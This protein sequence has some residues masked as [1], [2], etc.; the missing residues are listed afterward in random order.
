MAQILQGCTD[1]ICSAAFRLGGPERADLVGDDLLAELVR[2][3][4]RLAAISD[5]SNPLRWQTDSS[6]VRA[7]PIASIT[8]ATPLESQD[9]NPADARLIADTLGAGDFLHG[10]YAWARAGRPARDVDDTADTA[11]DEA[12]F[13]HCLSFATTV[14]SSSCAHR[15]TRSWLTELG[16][17]T[18]GIARR[19]PEPRDLPRPPQEPAS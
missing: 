14:A 4:A 8:P 6:P 5:G 11:R 2:R 18:D 19:R 17:V 1:V 15:G 16:T 12:F 9:G 7:L 13:S 10:A 3:G